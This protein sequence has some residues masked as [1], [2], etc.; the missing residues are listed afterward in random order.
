[1]MIIIMKILMRKIKI[2]RRMK[3]KANR[4]R[5]RTINRFRFHLSKLRHHPKSKKKLLT[6]QRTILSHRIKKI[7]K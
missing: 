2:A 1:M 5:I 7:N 3:M 6:K 4:I